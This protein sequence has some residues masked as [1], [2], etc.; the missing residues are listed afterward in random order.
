MRRSVSNLAIHFA[1]AYNSW[2]LLRCLAGSEISLLMTKQLLSCPRWSVLSHTTWPRHGRSGVATDSCVILVTASTWQ[3]RAGLCGSFG[4]PNWLVHACPKLGSSPDEASSLD[5]T[6]NHDHE[7]LN[8]KPRNDKRPADDP[9]H[10]CPARKLVGPPR[11]Y[12]Q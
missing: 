8:H 5:Q 10:S 4:F 12:P 11:S 3:C 9:Q 6:T 1:T 2:C 7:F